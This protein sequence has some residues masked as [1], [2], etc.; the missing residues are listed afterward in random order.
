MHASAAY[1]GRYAGILEGYGLTLEQIRRDRVFRVEQYGALA[2]FYSLILRDE[3]KLHLA[4][5]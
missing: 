3:P 5:K 1:A 2:G 4:R